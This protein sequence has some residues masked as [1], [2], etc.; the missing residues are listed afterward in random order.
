MPR[1]PTY[2]SKG[3]LTSEPREVPRQGAGV[4]AK[5]VG[6][7]ANAVAEITLDWQNAQ[8]TIKY[9]AGKLS[10][11]MRVADIQQ[12]ATE[13]PDAENEMQYR[14]ELTKA[15]EEILSTIKA[16]QVRE[17]LGLDLA[18]GEK[19]GGINIQNIYQKKQVA[20]GK[21]ILD[22]G[23]D[24]L[25]QKRLGAGEMERAKIDADIVNLLQMNVA[26]KIITP[27]EAQKKLS[28]LKITA[29]EY[30]IYNDT[31]IY[32]EDSAVLYA[33]KNPDKK[34]GQK[35]AY[36]TPDE[37][38]TLIKASTNRI[39]KNHEKYKKDV[40]DRQQ[41][42]IESLTAQL[43][44][45]TLTLSELDAEAKIPVEDGGL[46]PSKLKKFREEVMEG[47]NVGLR[48]GKSTNENAEKYVNLIREVV[49]DKKDSELALEALANAY[50]N[51]VVDAEEAKIIHKLV[52]KAKDIRYQKQSEAVVDG[53]K[54]AYDFMGRNAI[55]S[56]DAE[57]H[58]RN[59]LYELNGMTNPEA[60]ITAL[61]NKLM[62]EVRKKGIPW[63][64]GLPISGSTRMFLDG[65][66]KRFF[67]DGRIEDE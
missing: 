24:A 18:Y 64:M 60:E 41:E 49:T 13:D 23:L 37:R 15:R 11:D 4:G 55:D 65:T 45:G 12:R 33:L 53:L 26:D 57:L 17:K 42:K 48:I 59:Y 52:S 51:G 21:V 40:T 46:S 63:M 8:N 47:I 38:L 44:D 67:P 25:L 19:I 54:W 36:L 39:S 22:K 28:D 16:P 9:T 43:I 66:I 50:K 61:N 32:E 58:L 34:E 31:A 10:Y 3:Q 7:V 14:V 5:A 35:Y 27:A 62:R 1:L 29:V 56:R 20:Y 30:D 6:D 2:S